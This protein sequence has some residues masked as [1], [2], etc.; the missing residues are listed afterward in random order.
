MMNPI[1]NRVKE[2][3]KSN[4]LNEDDLG[5]LTVAILRENMDDPIGGMI[6][7]QQIE[8]DSEKLQEVA[9]DLVEYIEAEGKRQKGERENEARNKEEN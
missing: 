4:N 5:N 3:A 6:Y 7:R 8:E 9:T 2:E 1:A